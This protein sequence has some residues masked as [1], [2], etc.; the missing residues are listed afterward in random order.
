MNAWI[1]GRE[2]VVIIIIAQAPTLLFPKSAIPF[3]INGE[4]AMT[5]IDYHISCHHACM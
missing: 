2:F 4:M 5:E 3:A 1:F